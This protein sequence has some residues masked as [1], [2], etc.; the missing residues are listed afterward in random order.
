MDKTIDYFYEISKIPRESGNE[1]EISNYIV[2]F[3]KKRN[4]EYY[5]DKYNNVIIK[6]YK[7]SNEPII[8]QAHL[9]MVCTKKDNYKFDFSKDPI[10]ITNSNGYLTALNTT[11]GADN[12]IGVAQILNILDSNLNI[13]IEAIFT[14]E[15]ETTMYGAKMINLDNIKGKK[16]ISFDG[17]NKNTILIESAGFYD[18]DVFINN[19][20]E[21]DIN[22]FYEI[23]I[24]NLKG[25]HSGLDIATNKLNANIEIANIL[26]KIDNLRINSFVGGDQN[27]VIPTSAKVIFS[28]NISYDELINIINKNID[29]L[30]NIEKSIKIEINKLDNINVSLNIKDTNNLIDS[31]T[32]FNN[33]VVYKE[34]E[35]IILS[36]N[37]GVVNLDKNHFKIGMRS[38]RKTLASNLLKED[39][40]LFDSYNMK[41]KLLDFQ[42]GFCTDKNSSLVKDIIKAY[43]NIS[44]NK[45]DVKSIHIGVEGGYFKEKIKDLEVVIISPEINGAHSP[46]ENV[47]IDSIY[48]CNKWIFEYLNN[49]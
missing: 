38:S 30:K 2:E 23:K 19:I 32:S 21:K 45:L 41:L 11:L 34:N 5:Q 49:L 29:K 48:E 36:Q 16:L 42:P 20:K 22:N 4:L 7:G 25:G 33:G 37:L 14:T 31:I 15:E 12:G 39:E 24:Y 17:F 13:N 46:G 28:T 1:K 27:N 40:K 44:K 18:I 6:H 10:E 43:K 8:L 3:A 47:N 35:N 26:R 9:D